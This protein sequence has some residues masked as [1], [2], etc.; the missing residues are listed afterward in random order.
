MK[1]YKI[2]FLILIVF[3]SIFII[4]CDDKLEEVIPEVTTNT[5]SFETNCDV[6]IQSIE[7][8]KGS[9]VAE[10]V[11]LTREGYT[12]KGWFLDD[13]QWSFVGYTV[14][15]DITL[16][17]KWE[18]NSYK[19]TY[20]IDG[21]TIK[22]ENLNYNSKITYIPDNSDYNF[23]GWSTTQDL[24]NII[25]EE[26][27]TPS[28]DITLYG[29]IEYVCSF[30][31]DIKDGVLIGLGTCKD[32]DIII[33]TEVT[34]IGNNAFYG[35]ES[36][37]SIT[38]P[39]TVSTI[40]R[41][42][43]E[44]CTSLS[45]LIIP[46]SVTTIGDYSVK[47]CSNLKSI[48]IPKSVTSI[49]TEAFLRC[50]KLVEV[51]NLSSL[52]ITSN[53]SDY[54]YV[55]AYAKVI[56]N[57]LDD[58]SKL[59]TSENGCVY[60][61]KDGKYELLDYI[62]DPKNIVLNST[63]N[64]KSYN[65]YNYAFYNMTNLENLYFNGTLENWCN[66]K[67]GLYANPMSYAKNFYILDENGSIEYNKNKYSLLK[68]ITVPTSITAIGDYQFYGI[69]SLT[70]VTL[71]DNIISIGESAF[72]MCKNLTK[73]EMTSNVKNI[74]FSAFRHSNLSFI[75]LS[76]SITTINNNIFAYCS[77]LKSLVISNNVAKIDR[78][79]FYKCTSLKAIYFEGTEQEW[80]SIAIDSTNDLN[81]SKIYYY[82]IDE[83]T[84]EGNY[85]HYNQNGEILHW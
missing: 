83:P 69:S 53:Y 77:N 66:F 50:Y 19:V 17:A 67:F 10:P 16:T 11:T 44:N 39:N 12:F 27:V 63:F 51:Y 36:I 70:R 85:W 73:I 20:I 40:E 45:K 55:A 64:D 49:G 41:C 8:P 14:T 52:D 82:S 74:G 35:C 1:K 60:Y 48:V 5:V 31:L 84:N 15:E 72:D 80:N 54:G 47:N 29:K 37:K 9:K 42:A 13:E 4:G 34:S 78:Y 33:P 57:S 25:S 56:Y 46:E 68:E 43:F 71:N 24:K 23:L 18:I 75:K 7:V 22:E 59:I 6:T 58:E 28:N 26:F 38:I 30:G 21:S 76:S 2:L 81:N 32:L 79:V 62:G 65:I 61:E 3:S